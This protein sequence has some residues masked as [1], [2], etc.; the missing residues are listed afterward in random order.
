MEKETHL[1]TIK[2]RLDLARDY[3]K[4]HDNTTL[5]E[6]KKIDKDLDKHYLEQNL[7]K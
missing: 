1:E 7:K 5:D 6:I 3:A 4:T 2:K